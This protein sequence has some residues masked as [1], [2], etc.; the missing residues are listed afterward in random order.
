[1][2]IGRVGVDVLAWHGHL[3]SR[4]VISRHGVAG[5]CRMSW[6]ADVSAVSCRGVIG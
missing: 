5:E 3:V 2:L 4:H 6:L 1:M